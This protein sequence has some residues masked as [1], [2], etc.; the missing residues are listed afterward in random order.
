MLRQ[1]LIQRTRRI[2]DPLCRWLLQWGM[3]T[4]F[5]SYFRLR[6]ISSRRMWMAYCAV[7][8]TAGYEAVVQQLL[9]AKCWHLCRRMGKY[10]QM[11]VVTRR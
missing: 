4:L 9:K 6:L 10:G 5:N 7:W 11:G 2:I 3:M 1:I 8:W